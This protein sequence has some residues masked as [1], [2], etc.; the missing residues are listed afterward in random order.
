[1]KLYFD[2]SVLIAALLQQHPQHASA[3]RHLHSVKVKECEGWITTHGLAELYSTL[4]ALPLKPR[5][6]P[7]DANRIIQHS[8]LP[9][10]TLVSLTTEHYLH[11]LQLTVESNLPSGAIYDALHLIGARDANCDT[12]LTFNLRHF[13]TLA[14]KDPLI[15]QP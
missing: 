13:Q 11:A 1:M 8:I 9:L 7:A 15:T 12:L 5:L 6:F 3:Y 4:S 10:F 14:P 2:T